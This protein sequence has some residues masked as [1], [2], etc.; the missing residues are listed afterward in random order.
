MTLKKLF[1]DPK[2]LFVLSAKEIMKMHAKS[3]FQCKYQRVRAEKMP[4]KVK[5]G[6]QRV[7]P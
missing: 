4:P 6:L 3:N 2:N 5:T 7:N 1:G